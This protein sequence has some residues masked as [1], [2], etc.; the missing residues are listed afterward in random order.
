MV[1]LS[2]QL[3]FCHLFSS[4]WARGAYALMYVECAS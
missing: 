4:N 3:F 2:G 1:K